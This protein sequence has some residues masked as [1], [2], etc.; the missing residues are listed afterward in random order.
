MEEHACVLEINGGKNLLLISSHQVHVKWIAHMTLFLSY[1]VGIFSGD[2][3]GASL[4]SKPLN[5]SVAS[6][7]VVRVTRESV[8]I[9]FDQNGSDES[10]EDASYNLIKLANDVTYK[11]LKKYEHSFVLV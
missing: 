9:A 4:V 6:G 1:W 7:I 2:I 3:V 11:R 8:E 10:F 5:E